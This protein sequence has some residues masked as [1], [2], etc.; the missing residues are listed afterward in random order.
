MKFNK[1]IGFGLAILLYVVFDF[2][3]VFVS[4]YLNVR[5]R[6]DPSDLRLRYNE[7]CCSHTGVNPFDVWNQKVTHPNFGYHDH[8][9]YSDDVSNKPKVHAYPPWHTTFFWFYGWIGYPYVIAV[10]YLLFGINIVLV[11]N[12]LKRHSPEG[13]PRQFFY[14]MLSVGFASVPIVLC[15]MYGNY[16]I[17]FLTC[18]LSM[19]WALERKNDLVVAL[20][21]SIL[22]IKPQVGL[23]FFWPIVIA[24]RWKAILFA[25]LLCLIAT[26]FPAI[27]YHCS[28]MDL[29]L[30]I[31]QIGAP[32]SRSHYWPPMKGCYYPQLV[33]YCELA[34]WS[35]VCGI[36]CWWARK[37]PQKWML[38]LP[39]ILIFPVWTYSNRYDHVLLI[40]PWM[41]IAVML[42]RGGFNPKN[43]SRVFLILASYLIISV[44][45]RSYA[46]WWERISISSMPLLILYTYFFYFLGLIATFLPL[47]ILL[48]CVCS[49]TR[50]DVCKKESVIYAV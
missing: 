44:L 17:L 30:Q 13:G 42:T 27:V 32:W 34:F 16:G 6:K 12:F 22:M 31:P 5:N 37:V 50:K 21:W 7:I 20:C 47:I 49:A 3:C 25:V 19:A 29:I 18:V 1:Y 9:P 39:V 10:L 43:E 24:R 36:A 38:L 46:I 11:F 4:N 40:F 35:F 33:Q 23:L 15:L 41:Y 48:G 45:V 8:P 28:P 14:W 2:Y 26:L